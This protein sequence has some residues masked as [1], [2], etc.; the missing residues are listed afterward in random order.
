MRLLTV[1]AV[2]V[3]VSVTAVATPL[4]GAGTAAAAAAGAHPVAPHLQEVALVPTGTF[5]GAGTTG[6][7]DPVLLSAATAVPGPVGVVGLTWTRGSEGT[8]LVAEVRHRTGAGWGAWTAIDVEASSEDGRGGTEPFVVTDAEQVQGRVRGAAADLPDTVRMVVVDPGSSAADVQAAPP[9]PAAPQSADRLSAAS[10]APPAITGR[11]AW[12][13]DERLRSGSPSYATVRAAVVHHTAGSNS[14]TAGEVP[15]VLRG[16]LA[17]HTSGRGWSD[18]GYNVLADKYGRLWEGRYGGLSKGVVGAHV[19]GYNTGSFGISVM[20]TYDAAAPPAAT[21]ESVARAIAWKLS[22]SG[23]SATTTTTLAGR[24][25]PTVVGHRDLGQT[26]CPGQAFYNRLGAIRERARALQTSAPAPAPAPTPTPPPPPVPAGP[27]SRDLDGDGRPDVLSR[28][29]G[30]VSVSL[31]VPAPVGAPVVVG[32]GWS[33]IDLVLGSPDLTGDR[34]PDLVVRNGSTGALAVYAGDGRGKVAAVTQLGVGWGRV[35]HLVAPGDVDGDGRA[36]V[37]AVRTD[38]VMVLY[39]GTG[40]GRLGAAVTLGKGWGSTTTVTAGRDLTGDAHPDLVVLRAD[41]TLVVY[42]GTG[43]GGFGAATVLDPAWSDSSTVV[44]VGDWDRDGRADVMSRGTDGRMATRFGAA[45]TT[46]EPASRWGVGWT[47]MRTPAAA[48]DWDG[49]GRADLLAITPDAALTLYPGTGARDFATPRGLAL[50]GAATTDLVVAAGDVTG[51]GHPDLVSR[52]T[53]GDLWLSPGTAGG[54]VAPA[55]Q[56]GWRWSGLD[57]VTAVGDLSG[58]GVPDLVARNRTLGKLYL[59]RLSRSGDVLGSS[60][61]GA[62]WNGIDLLVGTGRWDADDRTDLLTRRS[63]DG[64]LL[65]Y[66]GTST[67]RLGGPRQV[68]ARWGGVTGVVGI[69]DHD[70]DG[71]ADVL[72]RAPAGDQVYLGDGRGGFAGTVTVLGLPRGA[73]LS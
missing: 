66:S 19:A 11:A 32:R 6:S 71:R 40:G 14:Y 18:I 25:I 67:G 17:F 39:P 63:S 23:V 22:L 61:L 9:A 27:I 30:K 65:L 55:R 36:D 73:V 56:I 37:L 21:Q 43:R 72:V 42:A 50:A 60:E 15:A 12:G 57:L 54:A 28:Q 1:L 20:G 45:R 34:R 41:R 31:R 4:P 62:G 24:S 69:G 47:A 58:D 13:A 52:T 3:T 38:G 51:D 49:D 53:A 16:I 5:A 29:A 8:G 2:T 68:G 59:Y 35:R 26:A 33:A 10:V 48:G 70:R 46:L 7:T 44:G 64:A